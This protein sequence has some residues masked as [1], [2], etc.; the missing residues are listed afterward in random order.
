MPAMP[1]RAILPAAGLAVS[2]VVALPAMAQQL[3]GPNLAPPPSAAIAAP[4]EPLNTPQRVVADDRVAFNA[5]ENWLIPHYFE[6]VREKQKRA[7]RSK[8][9]E[10]NLPEGIRANPA[11]GDLLPLT[12]LAR[13]DRLPGPLQRE[14]PP[15]RPDTERIVVGKN[16]LMVRRSTGEV[17]D[18]LPGILH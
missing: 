6:Q 5:T 15:N 4:V 7:A 2:L 16:V 9:Y 10:R 17:L 1:R 18:I 11:K 14:L 13:L 8:K 12:L 3:L